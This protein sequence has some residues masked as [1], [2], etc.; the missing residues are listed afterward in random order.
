[1]EIIPISE[2]VPYNKNPRLNNQAVEVVAKSIK[3]FGFQNP[4]IL[5]KDNVI[6]AG[7]TRLKAA[8]KLELTEVPVIWANNL[9]PAQVKAYRIM[10]NK[11]GEYADWDFDA[12]LMEID[13]LKELD[14][15]TDLTGFS[16]ANLE[17]IKKDINKEPKEIDENL[18]TDH[19]CPK[20]GYKW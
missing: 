12:L 4:I 18:S 8:Q 20:C 7:H 1:M 14:F 9:S 10:D 17:D 19:Q 13:E 11:S 15:N 16:T 6:I 3:E 5:D 2:I